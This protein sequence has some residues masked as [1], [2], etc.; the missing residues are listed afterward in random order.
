LATNSIGGSSAAGALVPEDSD[1]EAAVYDVLD[2]MGMVC[3]HAVMAND[4][5]MCRVYT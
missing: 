1:R 3:A 4:A 5:L 2:E